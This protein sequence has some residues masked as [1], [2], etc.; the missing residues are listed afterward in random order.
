MG[1]EQAFVIVAAAVL[2]LIFGSFGTVVAYRVPAGEGLGGRSKC[3]NCGR[4]ITAVENIPVVSYLL[5]RGRCRNC[6]QEISV[7]YPLTEAATA[8]LFALAAWRFEVSVLGVAVAALFWV[9]VVLT[10]IDFEHKLL[11]NRIVYPSFIAAWVLLAVAAL[12]NSEGDRL[13]DAAIGALVFGGFFF[14]IAFIYPAGMG[15]G[16]IKLGS[17]LG[18]FLGYVGGLSVV[19]V[20]MFLS[21]LLG[22]IAS[23]ALIAIKGGG[24]KTQVPFGPFLALGTVIALFVGRSLVDAYLGAF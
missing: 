8:V 17:L 20:G 9:L 3:P 1:V 11:P 6:G 5:L 24:R 10:V 19:L 15:G 21:F 22:A 12:V 14:V 7:R 2:G 18:T 4:T 16:D 23:V 13:A